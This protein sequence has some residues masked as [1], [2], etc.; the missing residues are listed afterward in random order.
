MLPL[1]PS[2]IKE[3]EKQ[4]YVSF[5]S[6]WGA[7]CCI[8]GSHRTEANCW[9]HIEG[10]RPLENCTVRAERALVPSTFS[11]TFLT[12][13]TAV[14]LWLLH[15]RCLLSGQHFMRGTFHKHG[16]FVVSY[17]T[18]WDNETPLHR[19]LFWYL[20]FCGYR[21]FAITANMTPYNAS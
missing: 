2:L 18:G 6:L 3:N 8:S 9:D 16:C 21:S 14:A 12:W 5:K 1:S 15:L 7:V 10:G 20:T 13:E 11:S 19:R 17:S 4:T